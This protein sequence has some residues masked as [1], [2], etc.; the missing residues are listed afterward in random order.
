MG[1]HNILPHLPGGGKHDYNHSFYELGIE[2]GFR[3]KEVPIDAASALWQFAARHASDYLE[4]NYTPALMDW[5]HWLN[6][7]RSSCRWKLS[8]IMDGRVHGAKSP[9]IERRRRRAEE[10][11]A[12][13]N[14]SG[15]IQNTPEYISHA[16][17]ICKF[18]HIDVITSE[19]E[20][21]PQVSYEATRKKLIPVTSDSDVLAYGV[22]QKLV[23]VQSF[24]HQWYRVIDLGADVPL[25][26][27]PLYDLY[28]E[29]GTIVFQL[30]AGCSGCDFTEV[31]SGIVGIGIEKFLV[32]AKEAGDS[33][34][35]NTRSLA[36]T[37]WNNENKIMKDN[38][39]ES[40]NDVEGHLQRIVDVY[41][42]ASVYDTQSNIV[43]LTTNEII[44]PATKQTKQHMNGEV[45]SKTG[46]EFP[47]SLREEIKN[48]D[49][50]E[51]LH[52]KTADVS[53]IRGIRLPEGKAVGDCNVTE[54]R[55]YI[56]CRSGKISASKPDLVAIAKS[57]QF[58]EKQQVRNRYVDRNPN[59]N[60]VLFKKV[61][62]SSTRPI[63]AILKDLLAA[64]EPGS[65][66]DLLQLTLELYEG[67]HFDG[68]YD[69]IARCAP[70]LTEGF[71]YQNFGHIGSSTQQ[72][73]IGDALRR[74][75]YDTG[76]SYHGIAFVPNTNTVIIL[77]KIHASM[78]KDEKT[79]KMTN[80][81]EAPM[82]QEYLVIL[83]LIYKPTN[84]MK[85]KHHLGIFVELGR[86]YC[87]GGCV[88][89]QG[90]CRH[91]PECLWFQFHHWT[92]ERLGIDRPSTLDVCS[93]REG[94]KLLACDVRQKIYKQQPVKHAKS[95]EE[96]KKRMERNV[97]RDCTTGTSCDFQPHVGK[98]KQAKVHPGRF[99]AARMKPLFDLLKE[100]TGKT[101]K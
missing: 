14:L 76:T 11:R 41:V 23:I 52:Q 92:P 99:S 21:D 28:K 53:N 7:L 67:G 17:N 89:G 63:N 75:W 54:L 86:H 57:H 96:Q 85:D 48:M 42:G 1:I 31:Q 91:K 2:L 100:E 26:E 93:W 20:A 49:V 88:A 9:E 95:I 55:D 32:S 15:Q 78:A 27:K 46:E 74:C 47:D 69:N 97:K 39:F 62:T 24:H 18:M 79:R 87:G 65:S 6:Y 43:N 5:T 84:E 77:S 3:E 60:G 4:G 36:A 25:G 33:G 50:S 72:K 29:H 16:T 81:G 34:E 13:N 19:N 73:N 8:I 37:L 66:K 40:A 83:E 12:N 82:K 58:V 45:N 71:I 10:A 35:L 90:L 22:V 30:Y 101:K 44:S 98:R 61:D 38:K 80:E 68:Q 94:G 56:A 70:E 59:P 51:L 64:N